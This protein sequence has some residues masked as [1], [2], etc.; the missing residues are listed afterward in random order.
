VYLVDE[1]LES[2]DLTWREWRILRI[3][4]VLQP[5]PQAELAR[6]VAIDPTRMSRIAARLRRRGLLVRDPDR[7]DGRTRDL[8]VAPEGATLLRR[9]EEL[10]SQV[11]GRLFGHLE[12]DERTELLRRLRRMVRRA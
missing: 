9:A 4:A 3:V 11:E 2:L 1:Q 5:V 8:Y 12:P 10:V 6:L 7:W